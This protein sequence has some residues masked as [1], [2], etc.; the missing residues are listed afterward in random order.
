MYD[1]N[2]VIVVGFIISN[3]LREGLRESDYVFIDIGV[4]SLEQIRFRYMVDIL[5][6][7][8]MIR[9]FIFGN[10]LEGGSFLDLF[11]IDFLSIE[12][13]DNFVFIIFLILEMV[14]NIIVIGKLKKDYLK[15]S[16]EVLGDEVF[17]IENRVIEGD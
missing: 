9:S 11:I 14:R 5:F 10:F 3:S 16:K 7:L 1:F 2:D 13:R 4:R 6:G 12:K 8:I 15:F 17:S